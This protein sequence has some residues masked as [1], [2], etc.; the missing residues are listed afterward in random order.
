[1]VQSNFINRKLLITSSVLR[2]VLELI[3]VIWLLSLCQLLD[4]TFTNKLKCFE[5]LYI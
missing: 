2:P 5:C 1:M 4:L 3:I